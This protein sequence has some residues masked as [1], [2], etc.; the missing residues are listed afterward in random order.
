MKIPLLM[1]TLFLFVASPVMA[2]EKIESVT[3]KYLHFVC[4][5]VVFQ[6]DTLPTSSYCKAFIQGVVDEHKLVTSNH[7]VP[8]QYCLP[9]TVSVEKLA[10]VFTNFTDKNPMFL[11]KPAVFTLNY[12][13]RDAFPCLGVQYEK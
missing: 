4:L 7:N 6:D 5:D 13:L 3:T 1:V 12:A 2:E 10:R 11:D 9:L 8:E